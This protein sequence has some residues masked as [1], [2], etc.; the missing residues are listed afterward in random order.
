MSTPRGSETDERFSRGQK[1]VLWVLWLTYGSFYFCRNNL[2][3]ALP[4]LQVETGYTKAQLGTVLMALKLAYGVGQ[5]ING[6]LA[7]HGS[8]RRL[9]AAGLLASAALN[10]AFGWATGLYFL[11]FV[12]ACNGYVQALGWPPTMRVAANWF[13]PRQRGRAIG[14]IGTGYQL[15][16]ALTFVVAGWAAH[17]FG[18]RGALYVPALLVAASAVH[19]LCFLRDAP[20]SGSSQDTGPARPNGNWRENLRLT[21]ANRALWLVALA[22]CLLDACRYGFTD[23]GVTHLKEVQQ[24]SVSSAAFKYAVLPFG[25]IAGAYLSGWVTD[26]FFGGRRTPVICLLLTTLGLL[27]LA[28]DQLIH[29][30][31]LAS[32][33]VLFGVGFCIFGPQVLL[34]GTL[35]VDLATRGTAAAAAGFVNFMGYMGAAIGD[36]LTGRLAEDFGWPFAVR[37]WAACAFAAALVISFLWNTGRPPA[38]THA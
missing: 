31:M 25:G 32:V 14:L 11:T 18:W 15:C 8:P 26:R 17:R 1:Q 21:L 20:E 12:W 3:V 6:Q 28:Y 7:E 5:L 34:V 2:G 10:V 13:S 27:S 16:G 30:G 38:S 4:G 9:L 35:P 36:K 33:L 24:A 23:W 37:F 22:L 19:M 29:Q